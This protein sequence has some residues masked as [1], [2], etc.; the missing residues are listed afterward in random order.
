R[1][2]FSSRAAPRTTARGRTTAARRRGATTTIGD[3]GQSGFDATIPEFRFHTFTGPAPDVNFDNGDIADWIFTGGP[4]GG[5]ANRMS[6]FYSP[7]ISDPV[8]SKTMLSGTGLPAYR[9]KP[10][11]LGT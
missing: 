5:A 11:G 4:L 2:S 1:T 10:A 9:T 8:V 6:E 3:G 7:V